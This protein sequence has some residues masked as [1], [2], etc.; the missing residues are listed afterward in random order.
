MKIYYLFYVKKNLLKKIILLQGENGRKLIENNLIKRGFDISV[1]ECYKRIFKVIDIVSVVKKWR[2]LKINTIVVTSS[3]IL[4]WLNNKVSFLDK[5]EWLFK[6]KILVIGNRLEKIAKRIGWN[7][8]VVADFANNRNL[9][10]LI[11]KINNK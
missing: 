11:V 2:S 3:E 7:D 9:F 6:C 5:K 8:V 4:N 1:I 10:Q